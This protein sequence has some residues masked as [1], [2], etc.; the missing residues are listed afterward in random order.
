M[1]K[2]ENMIHSHV[3]IMQGELEGDSPLTSWH[4]FILPLFHLSGPYLASLPMPPMSVALDARK[5]VRVECPILCGN[6]KWSLGSLF[7]LER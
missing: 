6:V 4:S 1:K 5:H 2:S 7:S 3:D